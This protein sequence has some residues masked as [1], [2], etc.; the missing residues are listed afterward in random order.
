M[1]T[2]PKNLGSIL[3]RHRELLAASLLGAAGRG[4]L[5]GDK[6]AV[7]ALQKTRRKRLEERLA[8]ARDARERALARFDRE[9][10]RLEKQ[11]ERLDESVKPPE[12]GGGGKGSQLIAAIAPR[13]GVEEILGVGPALGERLKAAGYADA[14]AVAAA[15]PERLAQVLEISPS[16]AAKIVASARKLLG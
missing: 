12:P 7:L 15:K 13:P 6:N 10:E 1:T 9:I 2:T 4:E 3:E 8:E 5:P 14:A 11:I 16:R